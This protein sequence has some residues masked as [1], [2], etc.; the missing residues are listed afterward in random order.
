MQDI[1][2]GNC[3]KKLGSG[4]YLHLSIKC[5]RC[6]TLNDLRATSSESERQRAPDAKGPHVCQTT[7]HHR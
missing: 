2:C 4:I 5:P 3:Q 6:G 7:T 1:R